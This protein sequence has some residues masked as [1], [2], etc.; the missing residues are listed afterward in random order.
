MFFDPFSY[1]AECDVQ[2]FCHVGGITKTKFTYK[3][4]FLGYTF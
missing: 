2:Q 1:A 4:Y 3:L